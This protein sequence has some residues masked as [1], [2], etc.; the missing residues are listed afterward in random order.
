LTFVTHWLV[1]LIATAAGTG[2]LL[3]DVANAQS[4]LDPANPTCPADPNWSD[5]AEMRFTVQDVDGRH[6]LLAEGRIDPNLLPRL[7]A[8]LEAFDGDEIWLRSPGGDHRIASQAG[9]LLNHSGMSTRIPTDWACFGACNFMFMG[10]ISRSVDPG[11]WL[12]VQTEPFAT[13][14]THRGEPVDDVARSSAMMATEDNEYLIHMGIRRALLPD[15]MYRR[16]QDGSTRRCLTA[17][18][19]RYYNL[20]PLVWQRSENGDRRVIAD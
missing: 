2:A 6:V 17:E 18:E 9:I 8:A 19:L 14:S 1:R 5:Y 11:G 4:A 7:E 13:Q 15:I 20:V 12:V 3:S 10:G 16:S